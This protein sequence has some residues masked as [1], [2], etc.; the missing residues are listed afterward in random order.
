MNFFS[1]DLFRA[2]PYSPMLVLNK[3][4]LFHYIVP[5]I[6]AKTSTTLTGAVLALAAWQVRPRQGS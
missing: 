2:A 5:N 1:D 3:D 6:V 4:A